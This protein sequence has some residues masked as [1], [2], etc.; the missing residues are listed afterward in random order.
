MSDDN[1]KTA[2]PSAA[3]RETARRNAMDHF[4]AAERRDNEVRKEIERQQAA[5]AAKTAKLRAL[6]LAKE[7]A[8][9]IAAANAPAP[10]PKARKT[11]KTRA[12]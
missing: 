1:T 11:A 5:D 7:E 3:K 2:A 9:R 12:R 10:A 8:D 6:R 4:A